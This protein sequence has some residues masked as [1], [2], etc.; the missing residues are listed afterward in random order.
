MSQNNNSTVRRLNL[1]SLVSIFSFTILL[2]YTNI[3][4]LTEVPRIILALVEFT[5]I[6]RFLLK[7]Y[8][9]DI[10]PLIFFSLFLILVKILVTAFLPFSFRFFADVTVMYFGGLYLLQNKY[11]HLTFNEM[12]LLLLAPSSI[13]FSP[14]IFSDLPL[15]LLLGLS[16]PICFF[17]LWT[18]H[19]T[20]YQLLNKAI[21]LIIFLLL[22]FVFFPNYFNY[23]SGEQFQANKG[24]DSRASL[25]LIQQNSD[26]TNLVAIGSKIVILDVWYSGCGVCFKKFPE[27]EYLAKEYATDTN[28]Y[29]ATLNIPL[30]KELDTLGSFGLVE[31]YSFK[32]LQAISTTD[33]NKWGITVG[34]PT[35]L[36][37]DK[38]HKIRYS[39][40]LNTN[41]FLMVN[42]IHKLIEKLKKED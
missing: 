3:S 40:A 8:Q 31:E 10:K 16:V 7:K 11:N 38:K 20:K 39:G 28:L 5:L 41:R 30:K 13:I 18:L 1:L 36:V 22:A 23:K 6:S 29:I 19:L 2:C 15:G 33:E 4:A 35:L 37:F 25:T 12:S 14:L 9:S 27:F 34:Y 26:S 32:K 21:S 42:N 24:Q 17:L